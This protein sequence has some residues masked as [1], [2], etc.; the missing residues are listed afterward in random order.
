MESWISFQDINTSS[1]IFEDNEAKSISCLQIHFLPSVLTLYNN[2]FPES[3]FP[4]ETIEVDM[5][6][7][8]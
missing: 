8:F 2:E 5:R 1:E 4:F 6:K 7:W 3:Y